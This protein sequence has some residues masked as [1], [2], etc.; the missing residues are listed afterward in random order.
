MTATAGLATSI[1]PLRDRLTIVLLTHDCS[2]WV[3]RTLEE[4]RRLDVPVIVVDNA[5]S[6]D[7]VARVRAHGLTVV[8]LAT[9]IGAAAR[10]IG[11]ER[12]ATPYVAFCDDDGWYESSGLERAVQVLDRYPTL[13]VVNA[14]I[15]VGAEERLDPISRE[16][17]QSPL[18]GQDDIPGAVLVGF[19]AGAVVMRRAAFLDVGGYDRRFFI[20]GEEE[21]VAVPLLRRGWRM[22]YLPEVVV[23][24]YPSGV[25]ASLIRHFG[26]R[27]TL[28]NAWLHRPVRSAAAWTWFIVRTTPSRR[29][30]ARGLMMFLRQ[31][32]WIV[33]DRT[34]MT[35]GLDTELRTLDERRRTATAGRRRDRESV[36]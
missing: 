3:D 36:W 24:H 33:R 13:A 27:N 15:L 19:M 8:A 21:T 2:K 5:S 9:N 1:R 25:N 16:M 22:R 7:T 30:L 32:P 23:H 4:V 18:S 12:A 14:R 31:A 34:V 17:E 11:A 29:A 20:G 35:H 26:V 6:D 10:N 28:V